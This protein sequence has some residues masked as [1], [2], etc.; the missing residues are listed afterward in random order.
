MSLTR[1]SLREQVKE[2]I[3]QKIGSGELTPNGRVVE[4]RLAHDLGVS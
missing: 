3:L 4:A 1:S 2:A